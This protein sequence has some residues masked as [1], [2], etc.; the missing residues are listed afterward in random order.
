VF[1]ATLLLLLLIGAEPVVADTARVTRLDLPPQP[2]GAALE[3]FSAKVGMFA[4]YSARLVAGRRSA[5]V[6]GELTP[7]AALVALLDGTGLAA[8]FTADNAF[9]IV[10]QNGVRQ[11]R[12][13]PARIG[14]AALL[15]MS[16]AERRYSGL[17]QRSV[18]SALCADPRTRQGDFRA[19]VRFRITASGALWSV[20]LL[21]TTG[22]EERDA[23]IVAIA[24]QVSV[25][26]PPPAGMQQPFAMVVLPRSPGSESD[27]P[28]Q[29]GRG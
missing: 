11:V 12:Q 22:S 23:A 28:S 4:A 7:Q 10:E 1:R 25:D 6:S 2:L 8:E 3:T 18:V 16:A 29:L 15:R 24:G 13:D 5:A 17:L 20:R 27:C 9:V 19:A 14:Q 26:E 21:G